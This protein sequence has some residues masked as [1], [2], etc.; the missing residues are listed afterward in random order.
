MYLDVFLILSK[1]ISTNCLA[2]TA[3]P[4]NETED[5]TQARRTRDSRGTYVLFK[6]LYNQT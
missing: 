5:E 3:H 6:C 1:T 2:T 4:D